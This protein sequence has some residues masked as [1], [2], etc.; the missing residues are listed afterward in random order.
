MYALRVLL[1]VGC[2]DCTTASSGL[3]SADISD[4]FGDN[5]AAGHAPNEWI[6]VDF[7]VELFVAVASRD[8]RWPIGFRD[9]LDRYKRRRP[10]VA[11]KPLLLRL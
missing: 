6:S 2:S 4:W 3:R 10:A 8:E 1:R 11:R 9:S 5:L 7:D